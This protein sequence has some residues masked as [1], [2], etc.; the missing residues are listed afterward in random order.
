MHV[1]LRLRDAR[2][3]REPLDAS[4]G[5]AAPPRA[6]AR[7]RRPSPSRPGRR[8]S[9]PLPSRA[10]SRR[11]RS[12]GAGTRRPDQPS[13]AEACAAARAA[14]PQTLSRFRVAASRIPLGVFALVLRARAAA[15][16]ARVRRSGSSSG[17]TRCSGAGRGCGRSARCGRRPRRSSRRS[18]RL[19]GTRRRRARSRPARP[20]TCSCSPPPAGQSIGASFPSRT[21]NRDDGA[22][23]HGRDRPVVADV[24][25]ARRARRGRRRIVPPCATTSTASPGC[26]RHDVRRRS[27]RPGPRTPRTARSSRPRRSPPA[28]ALLLGEGRL[29]LVRW[30]GPPTRRSRARAGRGSSR[31]SR[32]RRSARISAVSRARARSLE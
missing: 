24:I 20:C 23:G 10:A 31:T 32:P 1:Q 15:S 28:S 22:V 26:R 12:R 29:D 11:R 4:S 25:E 3:S 14:N 13:S 8:T 27:S 21:A 19:P 17:A 6:R 30:S 7:A 16:R 5:R 9:T 2:A 18:G